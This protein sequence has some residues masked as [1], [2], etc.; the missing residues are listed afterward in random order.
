MTGRQSNH[1][2]D[3]IAGLEYGESKEGY[4]TRNKFMKQMETAVMIAE[5]K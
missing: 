4:W 5:V 3:T 2:T 1:R